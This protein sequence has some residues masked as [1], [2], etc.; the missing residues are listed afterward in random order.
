MDYILPNHSTY[1][2]T[3][4]VCGSPKCTEIRLR[5]KK[6]NNA[7]GGFF[8]VPPLEKD[9]YNSQKKRVSIK[10]LLNVDVSRRSY[11]ALVHFAPSTLK[12]LC[13]R[14]KGSKFIYSWPSFKTLER[15]GT[16]VV[17]PNYS[18]ESAEKDCE[19]TERIY[20]ERP[21]F[22][23]KSKQ[24]TEGFIDLF[25]REGVLNN[26]E[27]RK[28]YDFSYF[29]R[30]QMKK[31]GKSL[32]PLEKEARLEQVGF[33]STKN[34]N[35]RNEIVGKNELSMKTHYV[36]KAPDSLLRNEHIRRSV[37]SESIQK[38]V[39][40]DNSTADEYSR[41]EQQRRKTDGT[42]IARMIFEE[43]MVDAGNC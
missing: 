2:S 39:N 35:G 20:K 33:F 13:M 18:L 43:D 28:L 26:K 30:K 10:S 29:V 3:N 21:V 11:V 41:K 17:I 6:M 24:S 5:F 7:R 14:K 22:T 27:K 8:L 12:K 31:N 37:E 38:M 15:A 9:D 16:P 1:R 4:C 36:S 40:I 42:E 34:R 23:R 32:L 19:I 25:F